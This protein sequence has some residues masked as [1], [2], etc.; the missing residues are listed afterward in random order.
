M[1]GNI[2]ARLVHVCNIE[3]D[4]S[5]L[6]FCHEALNHWDQGISWGRGSS[7]IALPRKISQ[8]KARNFQLSQACNENWLRACNLNAWG[9][10]IILHLLLS[11]SF[12]QIRPYTYLC[13][14]FGKCSQGIKETCASSTLEFASMEPSMIIVWFGKGQ[15]TRW[16]SPRED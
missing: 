4:V 1:H 2:Y 5:A 15:D 16:T 14:W 11:G 9:H 10:I 8:E 12:H 7:Q 13:V 3:C 6:A